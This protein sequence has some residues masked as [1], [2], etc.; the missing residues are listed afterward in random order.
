MTTCALILLFVRYELNWNIYNKN[1]D[2]AYR[3][4][5]KVLFNDG[6]EIYTQTG[7]KLA[8]ELKTKVP[9][10]ENST[11]TGYIWDEYLSSSD[12][13]T[14]NEDDGCYADNNIFK[15]LTFEFVEGDSSTALSEPYSVVLTQKLA[16]KYF[17]GQNAFGKIIKSSK[18]KTLQVTG[19]I[20]DL[21][22]NLDFR[23]DY[24]VSISTYKEVSDWKDFDGLE[25]I[26][27][28]MFFTFVTLK[29]NVSVK[30]VNEKIYDFQDQ[31][32]TD[33]YKKIYLKP[34]PELHLTSNE[35]NDVEIALYYIGAFAVFVLLL[36]CI[37][38][39]N[40]SSANSFLRKK[41]I[42]VRKVVGASRISLF[43]QFIGEAII[44]VIISMVFTFL[45]VELLLPYFN[46]VVE[47]QIDINFIRDIKFIF[48]M[49]AVFIVTGFLSG[50]YPASYLSGFR[51]IHVIKGNVL[52]LQN[53]GKGSSNSFLRKSLVTVQYCVSVLL[54]T[55]T[56]YVVNQ[57]HYMKTKDFGFEKQNLLTC[58]VY[59]EANNGQ[60][61]TLRNRLLTNSDILDAT[62]STNAPF[63][64]SWGKEINWEGATATDKINIRYNR[65]GYDFIDTYKM[66]I[67]LGRNF[68]REFSTDEHAC[69]INETAWRNLKWDDPIGKKIDNNNYT[70]IGIVKDFHPY[71]VHEKIPPF[72]M[73]LNSGTLDD[74]GI[75]S[76]RIK[77]G[78]KEGTAAFVR[79]VFREFF[80]D[81]IIEVTTFDNNISFGT[82]GVWE[83][84]EKVFFGF[85][86]IAVLIAANGLFGM[87]S[88]A[89]QRRMKEIGVRKVFGAGSR[90]LYILMSKEFVFI[91]LF[92]ALMAFPSG[93]LIRHT[94][95]GA[96]KYQML[97]GDYFFA[98][99]VIVI[100]AIAATLYHTTKAVYSNPVETL[101]EE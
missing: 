59:G 22:F 71:S 64:G 6:Y 13:L 44:F 61:E 88:F 18:N 27:T 32:L 76:I 69:L 58:H 90:Q 95:P 87:I 65:V 34:L 21:P 4:Q 7:Y 53:S 51:P 3:V 12:E 31:Y 14:F 23:P 101:R 94:T 78:D 68:S 28:A 79:N 82:K 48:V 81:A 91:L 1:Y 36:A 63:H 38:Y 9:E 93:Y 86:V 62:L 47:R 33:N 57:V 49:F 40:L 98:I 73:V 54:L 89:A 45:F 50:I 17:P 11:V 74:G 30:S 92:A 97:F 84:V 10:I 16:Q 99:A 2:H 80:P 72:Y 60:F 29:P 67:I 66:K 42:G 96:Y 15:V 26:T 56:V 39:I 75:F 85:A 46:T 70:I 25:N 83:I 100:T 35:K 55:S 52:S 20:K 41:E 77:P 24:I 5:Q 37:N 8:S 19:I 43:S